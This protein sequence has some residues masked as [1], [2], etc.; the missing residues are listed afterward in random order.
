M[1]KRFISAALT[2]LT[3]FVLLVLLTG[4]RAG[5]EDLATMPAPRAMVEAGA[6]MSVADF[7]LIPRPARLPADAVFSIDDL[8]GQEARRDLPAGRPVLARAIGPQRIVRR[9]APVTMIYTAGAVRVEAEGLALADAAA[10]ETVRVANTK[11]R[12]VVSGLARA[13]GRVEV[14]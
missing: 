6:V 5:A 2:G 14:R 9:N 11:T 3:L 1:I 13:D 8:V 10:G 12:R 7:T 4:W